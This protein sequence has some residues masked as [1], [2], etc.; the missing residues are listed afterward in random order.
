MI[1]RNY[2]KVAYRNIL[3]NKL[4]S[5]INILG[6]AIGM[7][8]CFFI[9]QYVHFESGYDRFNKNAAR[10][11]RIPIAYSGSFSNVPTTAANHPAVGPALKAEFPEVEAFTRV[12]HPSLFFGSN[13]F[14]YKHQNGSSKVFNEERTYLADSSFFSVFT[15]QFISGNPSTA[16]TQPNTMVISMSTAEKYFGTENPIGKSMHLNEFLNFQITGVFKDVPQNSHLKFDVLLSFS[17]LPANM[18]LDGNWSWPE[19]YNYIMLT[20]GADPKKVESRFPGFIEKHLGAIHR[21]LQFGNTFYLQPLTDIHLNSNFLKE[22]EANGSKKEISF[23]AIIGIFILVIAWINYVNLSTA[24]S[25]E[26]GKE[27]G[28]RKV[29]GAQRSQLVG[30]FLFESVVINFFALILAAIIVFSLNPLYSQFIGN[31]LT[32]DFLHRVWV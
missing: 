10:I 30:Q 3:R 17:T 28:L 20:P 23:L 16:L 2:A 7:A 1:I 24:K 12:V 4:Y 13:T 9:F 26:R 27:V 21:E 31:N 14:S 19:Y 6:L 15:Y 8:A 11:Y 32:G 18:Q 25:L 29:V 5:L 22:A